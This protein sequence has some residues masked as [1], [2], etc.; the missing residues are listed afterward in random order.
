M[1]SDLG[2][3]YDEFKL[4]ISKIMLVDLS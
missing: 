4:L 1:N 3:A 2:V